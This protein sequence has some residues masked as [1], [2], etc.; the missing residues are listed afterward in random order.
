M[1][2]NDELVNLADVVKRSKENTEVF[3]KELVKAFQVAAGAKSGVQARKNAERKDL[4][5][6]G[7]SETID[8]ELDMFL[9]SEIGEALVRDMLHNSKLNKNLNRN[10]ALPMSFESGAVV[11]G[12]RR[13]DTT[14]EHQYQAIEHAQTKLKLYKTIKNAKRRKAKRNY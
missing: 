7:V 12:R 13:E 9:E 14:D 11:N 6:K 5:D 1:I 2:A 3:E 4:H 8:I 10:Q